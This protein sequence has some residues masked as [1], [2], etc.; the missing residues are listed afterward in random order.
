[1]GVVQRCPPSLGSPTGIVIPRSRATSRGVLGPHPRD[2]TS[3]RTRQG[4]EN[5][6][7]P[8][9]TSPRRAKT[10]GRLRLAQT[11]RDAPPRLAP[12]PLRRRSK[13]ESSRQLAAIITLQ[14]CRLAGLRMGVGGR[15]ACFEADGRLARRE[16]LGS[17]DPLHGRYCGS[18]RN[19]P[20]IN[21]IRAQCRG[22]VAHQNGA[23]RHRDW[24]IAS[25]IVVITS[26]GKRLILGSGDPLRGWL[27]R[28]PCGTPAGQRG[29]LAHGRRR[30]SRG[31]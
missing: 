10:V 9:A 7:R 31:K 13:P 14:R 25:R 8:G 15:R 12:C 22:A 20:S 27:E 26:A 4:Q 17:G 30:F 1:M 6:R 28:M 21:S 23:A 11:Q 5:M 24:S 29:Q 16:G 3:G 2:V 19:D 18:A